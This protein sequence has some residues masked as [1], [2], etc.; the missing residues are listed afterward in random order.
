MGK[1]TEHVKIS[2]MTQLCKIYVC[3]INYI[4]SFTDLKE[5]RQMYYELPRKIKR[6]RYKIRQ[7]P[8]FRIA[9][10]K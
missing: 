5:Q 7:I 4:R 3:N 8:E 1:N 2:I 10:D 9:W 6:G